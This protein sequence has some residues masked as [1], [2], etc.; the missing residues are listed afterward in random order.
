MPD[1]PAN[2]VLGRKLDSIPFSSYHIAVILVLGLVG[3][4]DGYDL[5]LTG[6]L[7]VLAKE[8]LH[9]TPEQIRWLTI[10]ATMFVV[11]GGFISAAISDH[12]SRKTIIQIGVVGMTFFTLLIPFVQTAEQLIVVRL[13][14]GLGLGFAI[15]AP[16]PVAA[17][18]MPAQHRRTYGAIYEICLASAFALLPLVAGLLVGSENGFRW[19]ALPGGLALFIVPVLVHFVIPQSARWQLRRGRTEAAIETVNQF[20]RRCGNRVPP[21]TVD[22]LGPNLAETRER[23]PRFSALF[24]PGQFRWTA[25]GIL[26]AMSAGTAYYMIAILLPKA[27]ID[28]G[29]LVSMSFGITTIVFLSTIPGKAFNAV[30]MERIGRRWTIAYSLSGAFP[31]LVLMATAHLA[32]TYAPMMMTI[33][34]VVLGF[35]ALSSFTATRV[36]LSEQFPTALRGRGNVF[37]EAFGRIF[38]G[39]LAPFLIEPHTGDAFVFFGTITVVVMCGAF[40]PLLFGKETVGQLEMVTEPGHAQLVPEPAE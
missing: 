34:A 9:I 10:A 5:A 35:T 2:A 22:D 11:V 26:T 23:L 3:F 31:G 32:G 24:A 8:P 4:T 38:A 7:L 14:T 18:L 25:V 15:T 40:I 20:I 16:F 17:E 27:L 36:Y 19:I 13:L 39:V 28:Q 37:G 33:G 6:S 29:A 12:V 1:M 30:L 21:L